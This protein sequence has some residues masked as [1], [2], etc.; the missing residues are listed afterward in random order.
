MNCPHC[1]TPVPA[2]LANRCSNC[3][4]EFPAD[5]GQNFVQVA[6]TQGQLE[7]GQLMSFLESNGIPSMIRGDVARNIYG[8]TIDGLA[9]V[10]VMVPEDQAET[11]RDLIDKVEHGE[12][13]IS[14]L[15]SPSDP[16]E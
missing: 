2:G 13:E 6:R 12:L 3:G 10:D 11:A 14:E 8:F 7:T 1:K 9:A 5:P 4:A 16:A 15:D